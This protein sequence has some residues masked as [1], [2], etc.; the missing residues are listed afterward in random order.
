[1][2]LLIFKQ[3]DFIPLNESEKNLTKYAITKPKMEPINRYL[4][5][6]KPNDVK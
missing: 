2:D 6:K 3:P 5:L 1:M 4:K